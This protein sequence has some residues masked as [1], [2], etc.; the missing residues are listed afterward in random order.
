[1]LDFFIVM[2]GIITAFACLSALVIGVLYVVV[3]LLE[4]G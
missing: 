2:G 3:R 1:M 4:N